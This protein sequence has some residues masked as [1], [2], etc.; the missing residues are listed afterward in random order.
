MTGSRQSAEGA[1]T[2]GKTGRKGAEESPM[3]ASGTGM[4]ERRDL[5]V[6]YNEEGQPEGFDFHDF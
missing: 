5:V 6:T 1:R 2:P 4:P 3:Q